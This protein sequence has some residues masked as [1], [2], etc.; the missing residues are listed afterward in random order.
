MTGRTTTREIRAAD[1]EFPYTHPAIGQVYGGVRRQPMPQIRGG[2][3]MP[4]PEM[5]ARVD[6][7]L[8]HS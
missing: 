6:P 7:F 2:Q 3:P 1:R 5:N 4:P 8:R